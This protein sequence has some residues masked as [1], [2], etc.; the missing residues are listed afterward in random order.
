MNVKRVLRR[1]DTIL[2]RTLALVLMTV[3]LLTAVNSGIILVRGPPRTQPL[4]AH[5]IARLLNGQPIAKADQSL[6][7]SQSD[8]LPA[9][10]AQSSSDRLGAYAVAHYLGISPTDVRLMRSDSET[11]RNQQFQREFE[12]YGPEGRFNPVVFGSFTAAAKGDDGQWTV[13]R[14]SAPDPLTIWKKTTIIRFLLSL[15]IVIP[16][17]WL[18]SR[19]LA[20]P[21]RSFASAA[22]R[23]GHRREMEPVK[24]EGPA[25]IRQAAIAVNEMQERLQ[26]YLA[27]RA[28]MVGAIA[29]DLRTPL[30]RL[31]FHLAKAS[32]EIREKAEAEIR[33]MEELIAATMDFVQNEGRPRVRE[34][35]DLGLLVEGVVD[36]CAD[37]GHDVRLTRTD[38]VT[39]VGDPILLKQLFVNLINNAISYG[40]RAE[41]A[42]SVAQ[43][44]AVV[45]VG[46]EGPGLSEYDIAR[47]FEP[48][49]RAETSRNRATGG[50]GLGLAIVKAAAEAHG[51]EVRLSNRPSGG[52]SARVILPLE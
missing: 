17:A 32:D 44:R 2:V 49:Y 43:G 23:I 41:V 12:L 26:R 48:F 38:R 33:E 6:V 31:N 21:I 9:E 8:D 19:R 29:H 13:L 47:V 20:E 18:F 1:P 7:V 52:L 30:S 50:M 28:S 16:I 25:E 24:V 39:V 51:G 27:E 14:S 37:V 34:P 3:V 5:E 45:D 22:E 46:D 42:L 15:L 35:V 4:T 10:L 36:D 40:A 11:N